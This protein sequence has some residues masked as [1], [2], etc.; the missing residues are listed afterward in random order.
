VE[1]GAPPGQLPPQQQPGRPI[2]VGGQNGI[3]L[4]P[5]RAGGILVGGQNGVPLPPPRPGMPGMVGMPGMPG[6][7]GVPGM[8]GMYG[9]M[10]GGYPV[11]MYPGG[12]IPPGMGMN[13][14]FPMHPPPPPPSHYGPGIPAALNPAML[15]MQIPPP[16]PPAMPGGPGVVGMGMGQSQEE[17]HRPQK[18]RSR[19]SAYVDPLDPSAKGYTERYEN[20]HARKAPNSSNSHSVAGW[21]NQQP[22][23]HAPVDQNHTNTVEEQPAPPPSESLSAPA[24]VSAVAEADV[25]EV[26]HLSIPENVPATT[27]VQS[28]QSDQ[29]AEPP[30]PAVDFNSFAYAIPSAEELMRRRKQVI[31]EA[32]VGPIVGVPAVPATG[33]AAHSSSAGTEGRGK[34][35]HVEISAGAKTLQSLL[36]DYS[37]SDDDD[38]NDEGV[39]DQSD[40]DQD[41]GIVID[42]R[43]NLV[44]ASSEPAAKH[45]KVQDSAADPY[46]PQRGPSVSTDHSLEQSASIS[47]APSHTMSYEDFVKS[48]SSFG[49]GMP[50]GT[51]SVVSQPSASFSSIT[52]AD[53]PAK[54]VSLPKIMKADS[55]LTAFVPSAIRVKRP[56][57]AAPVPN[58]SASVPPAVAPTSSQQPAKVEDAYADFLSEIS[59][60]Q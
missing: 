60:L 2:L 27:R 56:Q 30:K 55:A 14:M 24:A 22:L 29:P 26:R 42:E 3:P 8:P 18:E 33:A 10:P 21:T 36:G 46:A 58:M 48:Y 34:R 38:D 45:A 23:A 25:S 7:V 1:I 52:A 49:S 39:A 5:P 31:D 13:P 40:S 35:K 43:N 19:T 54:K 11:Q 44:T 32:D 51:E 17:I 37:D 16:P 41:E 4:P 28:A 20:P 9:I 53:P 57:T 47:T 15:P 6:M 50:P 12:V 59:M